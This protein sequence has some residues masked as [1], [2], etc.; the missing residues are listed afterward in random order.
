[1]HTT[2]TQKKKTC[3]LRAAVRSTPKTLT[4]KMRKKRKPP[5]WVL[6]SAPLWQARI[7]AL[8]SLPLSRPSQP[9]KDNECSKWFFYFHFSPEYLFFFQSSSCTMSTFLS[10]LSS[11]RSGSSSPRRDSGGLLLPITAFF[12]T[13]SWFSNKARLPWTTNHSLMRGCWVEQHLKAYLAN[14]VRWG[15]SKTIANPEEEIIK[16]SKI[17][18]HIFSELSLSLQ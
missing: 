3:C 17:L 8:S 10:L 16:R 1:M 14:V 4:Q 2:L 7:Q 6:Q 9:G 18:Y 11:F 15:G 13:I 5:L 12:L